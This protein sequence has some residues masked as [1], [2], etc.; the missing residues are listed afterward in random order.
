MRYSK[1]KEIRI[2]IK[3]F[4]KNYRAIKALEERKNLEN[5]QAYAWQHYLGGKGMG[6]YS[7]FPEITNWQLIDYLL[8]RENSETEDEDRINFNIILEYK[9]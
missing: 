1:A 4:W 6:D 5:G 2:D 7:L 3:K 9:K 8:E